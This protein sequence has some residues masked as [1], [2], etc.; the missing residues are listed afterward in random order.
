MFFV[1]FYILNFI[2]LASL[3]CEKGHSSLTGSICLSRGDFKILP[4]SY[5]FI[6]CPTDT[7]YSTS[8]YLCLGCYEIS[9]YFDT[10]E[11]KGNL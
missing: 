8:R 5:D 3:M 2:Y 10:A 4:N 11:L 7:I 6:S 1:P 9:I